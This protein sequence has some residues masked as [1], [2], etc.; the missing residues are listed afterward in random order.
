MA[1]CH[2]HGYACGKGEVCLAF[3]VELGCRE[4][5]MDARV[6]LPAV[7]LLTLR[8]FFVIKFCFILSM[9]RMT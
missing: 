7:K 6:E 1:H 2:P 5:V 8:G 3:V 9:G 4:M